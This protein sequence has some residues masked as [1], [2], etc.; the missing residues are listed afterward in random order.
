MRVEVPTVMVSEEDSEGTVEEDVA[1][2]SMVSDVEEGTL[3]EVGDVS[4]I[5]VVDGVED[6]EEDD[7]EGREEEEREED[8]ETVSCDEG[9]CLEADVDATGDAVPVEDRPDL[10]AMLELTLEVKAGV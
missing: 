8:K 7:E 6:D 9:A 5:V 3:E 2:A 10:E 4:A 1:A